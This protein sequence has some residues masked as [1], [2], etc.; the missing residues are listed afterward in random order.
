LALIVTGS[1]LQPGCS[2]WGIWRDLGNHTATMVYRN[3]TDQCIQVR[4][5]NQ[6]T[7]ILQPG[8]STSYTHEVTPGRDNT[9]GATVGACTCDDN[10]GFPFTAD[11]VSEGETVIVD[12]NYVYECSYASLAVDDNN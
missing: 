10:E 4:S 6:E 9:I 7:R 8:Q 1:L 3:N 5:G 11:F 2:G 12:V